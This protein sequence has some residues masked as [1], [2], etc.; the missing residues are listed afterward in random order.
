MVCVFS[1]IRKPF[2]FDTWLDYH[3]SIGV[4]YFFLKI[5]DTP[6]LKELV[7]RYPNVFVTYDDS[8]IKSNNYWTLIDRQKSFFDSIRIELERLK[9]DWIFHLDSD[10]LLCVENLKSLLSDI[11]NNYDSIHFSNYEGVYDSDDLENPFIDC[12]K[13]RFRKLLAYA[14][15]KSAAR[16]NQNL[17]WSGPHKFGGN[18]FK[19]NPKKAVVLHFES[20]TFNQWY[21]KFKN[22][23]T[24]D[25]ELMNKIPFDFYKK[26]IEVINSGD[27]NLAKEFYHQK[28]INVSDNT[29]RIYWTPMLKN[30]NINWSL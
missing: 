16:V 30:K 22:N 24:G 3:I 28:K 1:L 9:V 8:S 13:F 17:S 4:D 18:C 20:A 10:E 21:E 15:G 25:E 11:D 5:E 19:V 2:N 27:I 12:N 23:S 29:I 6:E 7:D 26:S 14:N